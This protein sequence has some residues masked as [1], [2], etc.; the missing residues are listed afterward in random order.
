MNASTPHEQTGLYHHAVYL[1]LVVAGYAATLIIN[2][3]LVNAFSPEVYGD[4]S[5][6][7]AIL[8]GLAPLVTIGLE[9][10]IFTYF[11]LYHQLNEHHKIRAF[12]TFSMRIMVIMGIGLA[13]ISGAF[14]WIIHIRPHLGEKFHTTMIYP[15]VAFFLGI[16]S[17]YI[18][19]LRFKGHAFLAYIFG[20]LLQII[21]YTVLILLAD[22]FISLSIFSAMMLYV[23]SFAIA[24]F[25]LAG[26][27]H[28]KF[29]K[30][31]GDITKD[32]FSDR[33]NWIKT[34]SGLMIQFMATYFIIA[35]PVMILEGHPEIRENSVGI[36]ALAL[37]IFIIPFSLVETTI[38][39]S[40]IPALASAFITG[41]R[42]RFVKHLKAINRV[43]ILTAVVYFLCVFLFG[44]KVIAF[45][46]PGFVTG[47]SYALIFCAGFAI[48]MG[49]LTT[50]AVSPFIGLNKQISQ[51]FIFCF[52]FELVAGTIATHIAGIMGMVCVLA[53]TQAIL[54]IV[55]IF[56]VYRK[57]NI[58]SL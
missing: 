37:N 8:Q 33:R 14:L 54:G 36:F 41:N 20:N 15:W 46:H 45:F 4:Y 28:S 3:V 57:L 10:A 32:A 52:V 40:V 43:S 22:M 9:H 23:S 11:P 42:D 18:C 29:G 30:L 13:L 38:D 49:M 19:L 48:N 34:G 25:V 56:M 24:I 47:Y 27:A 17:Y 35:L 12:F 58:W 16:M 53:A 26:L 6:L 51:L 7:V 2:K 50:Q 44:R 39:A 5:V 1:F 55:P 21:I 31:T